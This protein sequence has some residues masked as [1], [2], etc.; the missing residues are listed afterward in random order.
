M[1]TNCWLILGTMLATSVIAQDNTNSTALPEIPAPATTP[2][3][4]AQSATPV[5]ATPA[6]PAPTPEKPKPVKKRAVKKLKEPTVTLVPGLAE[7]AAPQ[8]NVRGQAGLKGEA[9]AHLKQG[10]SVNVIEQINLAKHAPNEPAQWAKI[11]YPSNASVWVSSKYIDADTKTVKSKKLNLRAG[12]GENYSVIGTINQG[13]PIQ[14]VEVKS[15]WMKIE[16]PADSYAFVAAMFLK[17]E[18]PVPTPTPTPVPTP[19]EIEPTQPPTMA[20]TLPPTVPEPAYNPNL[21]RVVS[22]EGVVR[23]V[24]SP[25]APASYELYAPDTDQNID[26]LY[27]TSTNLDLSRYVGMRIIATGEEGLSP[28]FSDTPVLTIESITVLDTNAVPR[29]SYLS[30]RQQGMVH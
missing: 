22:H 2:A 23:H 20:E 1:K 21:P 24:G 30:P 13:T 6:T 28:R 18:A 14:E 5:A 17:Q 29:R 7:I 3:A 8:V 12:P 26:F 9:I 4:E 11:S 10:E 19:T 27:T 25:I 15:G 16:P